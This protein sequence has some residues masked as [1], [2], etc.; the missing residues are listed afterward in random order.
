LSFPSGES[1]IPNR[2]AASRK[3]G[4]RYRASR[5]ESRKAAAGARMSGAERII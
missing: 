3:I 2:R 5:S 4:V 1:T